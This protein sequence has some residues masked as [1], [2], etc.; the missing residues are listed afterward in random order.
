[1]ISNQLRILEALYPQE[2]MD[3]AQH[4]DAIERGY[5]MHYSDAMQQVYEDGL[6]T[7]QCS[8]VVDILNM[9]RQ[10]LWAY[11]KVADKSGIVEGQI[12]FTGFSGNEETK[13]MAYTRYVSSLDG[14]TRF[15]EL[16]RGDDFNSHVPML[17]WYRAM[18]A[19]WKNSTNVNRLSKEDLVR[20]TSVPDQGQ[21]VPVAGS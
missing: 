17:P 13:Q 1:M 8:E 10:M 19:E 12:E 4:R 3:L 14:G 5:A 16:N 9:H 20:I 18:L 6:T 11:E 15:K 21:T 2:A 7:E